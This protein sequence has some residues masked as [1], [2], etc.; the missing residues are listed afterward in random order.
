MTDGGSE[1]GFD[2]GALYV[3]IRKAIEDAILGVIGTL[4]LVDLAFVLLWLGI[5]ITGWLES[6]PGTAFGAIVSLLGLYIGA[7]A[8]EIIPPIAD[9]F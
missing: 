4:L 1:T 7:A 6:R 5:V 3:V 8:L 2:E 9:W